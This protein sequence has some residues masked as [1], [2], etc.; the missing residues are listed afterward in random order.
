MER[1][2]NKLNRLTLQDFREI[3][4]NLGV[5]HSR[6]KTKNDYIRVFL[7]KKAKSAKLTPKKVM[8]SRLKMAK[9]TRDIDEISVSSTYSRCIIEDMG[10]KDVLK[11]DQY[12]SKVRKSA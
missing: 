2:Y 10:E 5:N 3:L 1:I 6:C 12:I 4:D 11:V 8:K 7:K 9:E